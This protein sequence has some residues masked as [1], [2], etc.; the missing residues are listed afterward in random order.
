M[1]V[2]ETTKISGSSQYDPSL[3]KAKDGM[4]QDQEFVDFIECTI[5]KIN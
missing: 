2:M 5:K 1:S 3:L 4:E